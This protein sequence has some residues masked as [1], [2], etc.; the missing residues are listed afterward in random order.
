[1]PTIN[2]IRSMSREEINQNWDEVK[3]VLSHARD[4]LTKN[5]IAAI[6]DRSERLQAIRENMHLFS[7]ETRS[8]E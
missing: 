2:D 1:M 4:P 8:K 6:K 5:E 3:L 7:K